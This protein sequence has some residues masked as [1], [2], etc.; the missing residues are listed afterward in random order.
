MSN[1][2]ELLRREDVDADWTGPNGLFQR[3]AEE[4]EKLRRLLWMIQDQN[5]RPSGY[6]MDQ[7]EATVDY[8]ER[9]P[10]EETPDNG[11]SDPWQTS[12]PWSVTK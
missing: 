5:F 3:A 8:S 1:L 9:P 6:L 7:I 12:G 4:I 2:L 10:V 11:P